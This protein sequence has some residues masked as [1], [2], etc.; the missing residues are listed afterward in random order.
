MN[1]LSLKMN[2]YTNGA[3]ARYTVSLST[4]I[5]LANGDILSLTFPSEIDVP[6][7]SNFYCSAS[8]NI[9][10]LSCTSSGQIIIAN[11]YDL[12]TDTGTFE[13][14]IHNLTNPPSTRTSNSLSNMQIKTSAAYA[15]AQYT[16]SVTVTTTTAANLLTYS[17]S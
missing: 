11:L 14:H 13:F 16:S 4:D 9:D 8:T 15:V 10:G 7:S 6:T 5:P 12:N 3:S 1:S 2:N 17:L